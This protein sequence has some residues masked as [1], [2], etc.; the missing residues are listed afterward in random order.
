MEEVWAAIKTLLADKA[1]GPDGYTGKFYKI[2]WPII[3]E[4]VME[5]LNRVLQGDV[6]KL[7]LLNSAYVTLL[8]K[9]A[10][11]LEVK[12]FRPIS[13]IHSFAKIVTKI[14]ANRLASR[15]PEIVSTNQSAFIKGRCIHDNFILVQQ[16]A[17][18]V[19]KQ[20]VP[21][22][23]LKL[24]IGKAFDSVSWPFLLEVLTHLGFGSVWCNIISKMLL[25]SSTRVLVNGEPGE[26][27]HHHRG[28]RQGDPLSPM[29][30]IIVMD[31]LNSLVLRAQELSLLQPV[32]RRGNG[33]RISLYADD[34]V[35][36]LQ[37][38]REELSVVKE[39]LRIFGDAS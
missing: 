7:H 30:F 13:L 28:L 22:I 11:A 23:L 19:Q 32:L 16:T 4:D 29:L 2:S 39:I 18:A 20:R 10:E 27:I 12:D 15:L 36:F 26:I 17:K 33:Q 21:R 31:V 25:S 5:A 38:S 24:D 14:L 35:M 1:P 34:V 37:P 6:S 3:K 9:K 8:P